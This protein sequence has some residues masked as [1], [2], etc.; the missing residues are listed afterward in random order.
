[1]RILFINNTKDFPGSAISLLNLIKGLESKG[2]EILV[3]GPQMET[4]RLINELQ[5][6]GINYIVIKNPKN[7]WPKI[8][9]DSVIQRYKSYLQWP[10]KV[11]RLLFQSLRAKN[12]MYKIIDFYHP[13]I[14]HSNS[15]VIHEGYICAKKRKIHHVFHLREYQDLDF[16]MKFFPSKRSFVKMLHDSFVITITED[17]LHH[18]QLEDYSKARVIYNGIY[19]RIRMKNT[20]PKEK[21][22]LC[23]SR[24]NE[25]KGHEDVI[26]AFAQF[27]PSHP[28]YKLVIMGY[29]SDEYV[30][31]LK[32]L[33][34]ETGCDKQIIWPGFVDDPF[35]DMAKSYA[36]IVASKSEGFGRMT[37]EAAFAGTIVIG[38][39]SGGT[40]E[41]L[42]K[43]GGLLFNSTREMYYA[44]CSVASLP[45]EKY[46]E[47]VSQAQS[48]AI[49]HYSNE[50]NVNNTYE[51]YLEVMES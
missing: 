10:I 13:D 51:F 31:K 28:D 38:R 3:V 7:I 9:R 19:P 27:A 48:Y 46:L 43:T 49:M 22:F 29:G 20:W 17:I 37:A 30:S 35:E 44:M 47:I 8:R 4:P 16:G 45:S 41:I 18:F 2:I 40:K 21:V 25:S 6:L 32:N 39:N 23:C 15:G 33:A 24:I 5:S 12:E 26:N 11:V 1:M 14:I 34:L 36:L 42:S 50:A